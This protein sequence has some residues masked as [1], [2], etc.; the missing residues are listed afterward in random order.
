MVSAE[1]DADEMGQPV[2][3]AEGRDARDLVVVEQQSFCC[4]WQIHWNF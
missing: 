3:E 2:K 4:L 1:V